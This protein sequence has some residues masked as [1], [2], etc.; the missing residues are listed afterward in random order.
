MKCPKCGFD[1]PDD[2]YCVKCGIEVEKWRS[3]HKVKVR[4]IELYIGV[5]G[6]VLA[7]ALVVW[8]VFILGRDSGSH[9]ISGDALTSEEASRK[10]VAPDAESSPAA[11]KPPPGE[12]APAPNAPA[13]PQQPHG[14]SK[15][16]PEETLPR[17]LSDETLAFL[18]PADH[19]SFSRSSLKGFRIYAARDRQMA[20][21]PFQ[22][23][24]GWTQPAEGNWNAGDKILVMAADLGGREDAAYPPRGYESLWRAEV[25]GKGGRGWAYLFHFDYPPSPSDKSYIK[26]FSPDDVSGR[27][28][29][30]KLAQEH[31]VAISQLFLGDSPNLLDRQK[32]RIIS[33]D[34]AFSEDSAQ[35]LFAPAISGPIM[36]RTRWTGSIKAGPVIPIVI[37]SEYLPDGWKTSYIIDFSSTDLQDASLRIYFDFKRGSDGLKIILPDRPNGVSVDG[38]PD[39]VPKNLSGQWFIVAAPQG[40]LRVS[41]SGSGK[42]F[43]IDDAS[44]DEQGGDPGCFGCVGFE[45]RASGSAQFTITYELLGDFRPGNQPPAETS[46]LTGNIHSLGIR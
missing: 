40:G 31:P 32:L 19:S 22:I 41:L 5:A 7:I 3:G 29:H 37:E 35:G 16:V 4:R 13:A 42:L 6:L 33:K 12:F 36:A 34:S 23:D 46:S 18:V 20:P 25:K 26:F 21:I 15:P 30:L 27:R 44:H 9:N 14:E 8:L 17:T 10:P 1:Q 43:Y 39:D 28:Y 45:F 24:S 38:K 11:P 2:I